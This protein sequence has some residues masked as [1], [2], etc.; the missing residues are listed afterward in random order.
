MQQAQISSRLHGDYLL[1]LAIYWLMP[2]QIPYKKFHNF[3]KSGHKECKYFSLGSF[4]PCI[5]KK[6]CPKICFKTIFD[7]KI[8]RKPSFA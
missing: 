5:T 2:F 8:M 3:Q 4:W 6:M 1:I 7:R